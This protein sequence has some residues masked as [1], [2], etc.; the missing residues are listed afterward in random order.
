MNWLSRF[1]HIKPASR[2]LCFQAR[3]GKVRQELEH[4]LRDWQRY[5][6]RDVTCDRNT[7][8]ITARVDKNNRKYTRLLFTSWTLEKNVFS[9]ELAETSPFFS[10]NVAL[11]EYFC[12][13]IKLTFSVSQVSISSP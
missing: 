4:L 6:V 7:M 5:G 2:A 13:N 10:R 3:R 11:C 12:K 9:V 8:V 1:L